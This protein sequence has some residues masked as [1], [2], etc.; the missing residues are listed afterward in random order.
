[1]NTPDTQEATHTLDDGVSLSYA[2]H[3]SIHS[4]SSSTSKR[5]LALVAHPWGR[6]GGTKN[7]HMVISTSRMLQR[8]G[9][10]VVRYDSR[11]SGESEGSASW[12]ASTEVDDFRTM[13]NSVLLP[14]LPS[15]S[16]TSSSPTP[17]S[18]LLCGYSF[19]SLLASSCPPPPS[20]AQFT[21]ETSYLLISYPLSVLWALTSFNSSRFTI[22]LEDR[23]RDGNRV[24]VVYGDKDQFSGIA[25][26]RDWSTRLKS[27]GSTRADNVR[28]V[29]VEGADH[30]WAKG[31]T[32]REALE[33]VKEWLE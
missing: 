17:V 22:A 31:E 9:Y 24:C 13:L 27:M 14:L 30:F 28:I 16:P 23:A 21:F 5:K 10:D 33:K 20:T 26:L 4:T 6:L 8:E 7:D 29:E 11:G 12:T 1:M 18:V 2:F 32:K 25:K 15:P 19:G 3:P